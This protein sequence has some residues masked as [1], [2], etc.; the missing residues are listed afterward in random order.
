[1]LIQNTEASSDITIDS[2]AGSVYIEGQE[3][4]AY[5]I[6][7]TA[8]GGTSSTMRLHNDTGTAATS[9][10]LVSDLGGNTITSTAGLVAINALG[11]TA[12]DMTLTAGD[13]FALTVTGDIT[14]SA[15]TVTI[16]GTTRGINLNA[17]VG[18]I[19]VTTAS[20]TN[21]DI[22]ITSVEDLTVTVTGY[23][24]MV[25]GASVTLISTT[26]PLDI[27]TA[28][29]TNG[30]IVLT[31]ADNMTTTVSG[32][33][34][35]TITGS[36]TLR[37]GTTTLDEIYFQRRTALIT[38]TTTLGTWQ[39]GGVFFNSA[40]IDGTCAFILPTATVNLQYTFC[41]QSAVSG[42][43]IKITASSGDSIEGGTAGKS[44]L[45]P[46]SARASITLVCGTITNW[47]IMSG[48]GTWTHTA[49]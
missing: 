23:L 29:T 17:T 3:N 14:T 2:V 9:I 33:S 42:D 49:N 4:I 38:A 15:A 7:I 44:I 37:A 10:E 47:Q 12:G 20:T 30:D 27:T 13:D 35:T 39:S 36:W 1:M 32:D 26:G 16:T 18:A 19:D 5:A 21:G 46:V 31:A 48:S 34:Y 6:L 43:I 40:G 25:G 11:V 45:S 24:N 28:S 41:D 22:N 8:D